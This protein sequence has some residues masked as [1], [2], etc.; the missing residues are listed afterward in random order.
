VKVRQDV[1]SIGPKVPSVAKTKLKEGAG[2]EFS[3]RARVV[4]LGFGAEMRTIWLMVSG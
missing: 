2:I 1:N 3:R 4:G